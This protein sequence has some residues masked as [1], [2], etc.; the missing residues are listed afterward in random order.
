MIAAQG[1]DAEAAALLER[2]LRNTPADARAEGRLA[3]VRM[4]MGAFDK[5][6]EHLEHVATAQPTQHSIVI[7]G[8]ADLAVQRRQ[9]ALAQFQ[10]AALLNRKKPAY[11][12]LGSSLFNAGRN[13]D[14]LSF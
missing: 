13:Q 3:L 5:A 12:G 2:P 14:A 7:L 10:S 4:Q 11:Q 8:V 1:R 6:I 9:D